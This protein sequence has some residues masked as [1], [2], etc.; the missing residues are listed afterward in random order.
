MESKTNYTAVGLTVLILAAGLI[1]AA[2]WLSVGFDRK[3]YHYYTVYLHES[4]G[5]LSAQSPVEY[6]GVRVGQVTSIEL[7][8]FDPKKVKATIKV[9]QGTPITSSTYATLVTQGITGA[10]YLGL[11]AESSSF[12]PLQKIPGEPYPVIPSKP[13]FLHR[14]E[15]DISDISSRF[16]RLLSRENTRNLSQMLMHLEK[17]SAAFAKNENNIDQMLEG[18][19]KAVN[20]FKV[21][22]KQFRLMSEEMAD[23][24]K[25]V[26]GTMD[27]GKITLDKLK[28]QTIPEIMFLLQRLDSIAANL[29][30]VSKQ[31]R[32]NPAVLIRGKMPPKPGPGEKW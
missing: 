8:R 18:L 9:E 10:T 32:E 4:V 19:P 7:S 24:G 1:T 6:N 16:E 17:I 5:G 30:K 13:S 22:A 25:S 3:T 21:S 15:K 11:A 20:E 28:Q 2:L 12:V 14:L 29:E 26:A 23:A 31:M 27:S